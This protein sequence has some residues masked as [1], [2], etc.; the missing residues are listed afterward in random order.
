MSKSR[1]NGVD[2]LDWVERFGADALR[3]AGPRGQR[4]TTSPSAGPRAEFAAT[5]PQAVQRDEIRA[6]EQRD[7]QGDLPPRDSDRRRPAGSSD[8]LDG[9][10]AIVDEGFRTFEVLKACEA[11][12]HFAWDGSATGT[13]RL[14]KGATGRR[15][16]RLD[17]PRAQVPSLEPAASRYRQ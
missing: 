8:R 14:A 2:P 5:S 10:L 16:R 4:A 9:V 3:F 15:T 17:C 12:Y 6:D 13:S 1:G 11:L 7:V